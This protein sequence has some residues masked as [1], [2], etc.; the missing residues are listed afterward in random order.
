MNGFLQNF[1]QQIKYLLDMRITDI[2]DIL[3]VAY[4]IY[5]LSNLIRRTRTYTVFQGILILLGILGLSNILRLRTVNFILRNTM[6]LGLLALVIL[7]QPELRRFL[8]KLGTS[9]KLFSVFTGGD[10]SPGEEAISQ[11]VSACTQLAE[12]K[13]GALIVFERTNKLNDQIRSGTVINADINAELLKNIFFVKAPLHD[14]A[15]IIRDWRI[16]AAG[17][18]LPL[19]GNNNLSKELGTRHRAGIGMSENSDALVVIISEETG[20]ISVAMDGTLKR[21][22]SGEALE[23]LLRSQLLP[24]TEEQGKRAMLFSRLLPGSKGNNDD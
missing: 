14:G 6:E 20:A 17:C 5:L 16:H 8:E 22:L 13:T 1:G 2:L 18:V 15:A 7:F 19:T 21:H 10:A 23:K 9:G 24:D 3:I 11:V 4:V 12:T